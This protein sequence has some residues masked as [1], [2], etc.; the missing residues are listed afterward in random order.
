MELSNDYVKGINNYLSTFVEC[1]TL[2]LNY[3]QNKSVKPNKPRND[4]EHEKDLTLVQQQA[5]P[6][7]GTNGNLF[8]NIECKKC[9]SFG[10]YTTYCPGKDE[11]KIKDGIGLFQM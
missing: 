10:H 9:N 1:F 8:P 2:L 6:I 11:N 4:E 5:K 7:P 3:V